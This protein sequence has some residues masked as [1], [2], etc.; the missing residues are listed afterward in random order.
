MRRF[1]KKKNIRE[2]NLRLEQDF[3]FERMLMTEIGQAAP[4][5]IAHEGDDYRTVKYEIKTEQYGLLNV[6]LK[7]YLKE[8]YSFQHDGKLTDVGIEYM[9]ENDY[10][11]EISFSING[12]NINMYP[13]LNGGQ[14]ARIMATNRDAINEFINEKHNNGKRLIMLYSSPITD[15]NDRDRKEAFSKLNRL[16]TDRKLTEREVKDYV[17]ILKTLTSHYEKLRDY[18]LYGEYEMTND[19]QSQYSDK[20]D[21]LQSMRPKPEFVFLSMF[22]DNFKLRNLTEKVKREIAALGVE[23]PLE[24]DIAKGILTKLRDKVFREP[25]YAENLV[26]NAERNPRDID[27]REGTMRENLY[28]R[29]YDEQIATNPLL[30]NFVKFKY[31]NES[32]IYDKLRA[33][34]SKEE[35]R[36]ADEEEVRK[37]AE[38]EEARR[39]EREEEEARQRAEEARRNQVLKIKINTNSN[40]Y[41]KLPNLYKALMSSQ[42]RDKV[43]INTPTN[44]TI[45]ITGISQEEATEIIRNINSSSLG[46]NLKHGIGGVEL[47]FGNQPFELN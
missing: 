17:R 11:L 5:E 6:F 38:R 8:R 39:I 46:L 29:T 25:T 21:L 31:Y 42:I 45:A 34:E 18:I 13:T 19:E 24:D 41:F 27:A 15:D 7:I 14:A 12:P 20:R 35:K 22:D 33:E 47:T 28:N 44:D 43:T 36:I 3:I 1:D 30:K 40:L 16:I 4:Y 2:A 32:G 9:G 10:A 37:R 26:R 23:N